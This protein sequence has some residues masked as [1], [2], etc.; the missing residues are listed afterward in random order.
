VISDSCDIR[1]PA[2]V[3][4]EMRTMLDLD[5]DVV[6]VSRKIEGGIFTA[7]LNQQAALGHAR[8]EL[9]HGRH[10]LVRLAYESTARHGSKSRSFALRLGLT[11][12][13]IASID[14]GIYAFSIW[15]FDLQ[16]IRARTEIVPFFVRLAD[17]ATLP[18]GPAESIYLQMLDSAEDCDPRPEVDDAH[19]DAARTMLQ[20]LSKAARQSLYSRESALDAARH[21]RRRATLEAT[22]KARVRSAQARLEHLQRKGAA[23][24]AIRM[25]DVKLVHAQTRYDSAMAEMANTRRFAIED[26]EIAVGIVEI[27]SVRGT[28]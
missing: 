3:A 14:T 23:E 27:R 10:P 25:A 2:N 9:I 7:T 5:S 4:Q 16:G 11:H 24:F 20:T 13:R 22:L 6:R 15:L 28:A 12:K 17:H 1:L 18:S 19:L 26:E 8:A 21:L